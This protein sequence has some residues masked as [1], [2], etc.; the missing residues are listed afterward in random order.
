[1]AG[2]QQSRRPATTAHTDSGTAAAARSAAAGKN[3]QKAW[4]RRVGI[5]ASTKYFGTGAKV[6][7]IEPLQSMYPPGY[8]SVEKAQRYSANSGG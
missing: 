1:M 7:K 5:K 6:T 2:I 8:Q 3:S 4:G